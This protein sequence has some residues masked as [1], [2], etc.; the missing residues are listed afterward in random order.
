MIGNRR[1]CIYG[2]I[3]FGCIRCIFRTRSKGRGICLAE[4]F[5]HLLDANHLISNKSDFIISIFILLPS[6]LEKMTRARFVRLYQTLCPTAN[7][8]LYIQRFL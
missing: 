2:A 3:C 6:F 1:G 4:P 7:L 8:Q 5:I